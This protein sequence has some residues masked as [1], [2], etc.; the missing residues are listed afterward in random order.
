[1][2]STRKYVWILP[3]KFSL[4]L[5]FKNHHPLKNFYSHPCI[6]YRYPS[7]LKQYFKSVIWNHILVSEFHLFLNPVSKR[8][9]IF[10]YVLFYFALIYTFQNHHPKIS[11]SSSN[12]TYPRNIRLKEF[13]SIYHSI[14]IYLLKF[15]LFLK[16]SKRIPFPFSFIITPSAFLCS[17]YFEIMIWKYIPPE[18]YLF[19]Y[20]TIQR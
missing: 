16:P 20:V 11:F 2:F 18:F 17:T 7:H 13:H 15:Y 4:N 6:F 1:M 10:V 3:S 12:S 8:Y 5:S 14:I 9:S 19:L